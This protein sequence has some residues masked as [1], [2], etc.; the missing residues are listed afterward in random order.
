M[1]SQ[2]KHL[3]RLF[4]PSAVS[5]MVV[6]L[7]ALKH[8]LSQRRRRG[9]NAYFRQFFYLF[10]EMMWTRVVAAFIQALRLSIVYYRVGS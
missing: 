7:Q 1:L 8:Y 10:G 3:Q 2:G 4:E 6:A 5:E 9:S